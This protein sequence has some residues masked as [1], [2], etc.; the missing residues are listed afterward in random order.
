MT[1]ANRT[2][3]SCVLLRADAAVAA[4][5]TPL[6][7]PRVPSALR[8]TLG[9]LPSFS[10]RKG[11]RSG[12]APSSLPRGAVAGVAAAPAR[13]GVCATGRGVAAPPSLLVYIIKVARTGSKS[14][15]VGFRHAESLSPPRY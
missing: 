9:D 12:P 4:L 1:S 2:V 8:G 7:L 3:L 5:P 14:A 6:P 11:M 15:L 13:P 10:A